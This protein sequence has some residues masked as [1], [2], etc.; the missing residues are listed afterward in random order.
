MSRVVYVGLPVISARSCSSKWVYILAEQAP[1]LLNVN[2]KEFMTAVPDV[3][4]TTIMPL[5]RVARW[6]RRNDAS[7]SVRGA[8]LLRDPV[9]L[10]S[11][12][13]RQVQRTSIGKLMKLRLIF[14][15]Y[16]SHNAGVEGSSPSLSTIDTRVRSGHIVTF[17]SVGKASCNV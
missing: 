5:A 1:A 9:V 3:T 8:G 2:I 4:S 6:A 11:A 15:I 14:S 10:S 17:H 16:R 12:S 7:L 13:S